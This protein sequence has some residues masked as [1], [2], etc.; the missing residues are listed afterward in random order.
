METHLSGE[1]VE[2]RGTNLVGDKITENKRRLPTLPTYSK[3]IWENKTKDK[4][5]PLKRTWGKTEDKEKSLVH[6]TPAQRKTDKPG[7]K[8]IGATGLYVQRWHQPTDTSRSL[9]RLSPRQTLSLSLALALSLSPQN[10]L[11]PNHPRRPW[12]CASSSSAIPRVCAAASL[13]PTS[14]PS[15]LRSTEAAPCRRCPIR[16][17]M[18]P[19]MKANCRLPPRPST[20][21]QRRLHLYRSSWRLALDEGRRCSTS[22]RPTSSSQQ[23]PSPKWV[24]AVDIALVAMPKT[25]VLRWSPVTRRTGVDR[26]VPSMC[27]LSECVILILHTVK[28]F[29]EHPRKRTRQT[30]LWKLM[31]SGVKQTLCR[32]Y[33]FGLYALGKV[34]NSSSEWA[35]KFVYY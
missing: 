35:V 5:S 12:P 20:C 34:V 10:V 3:E 27:Y 1:S 30:C 4:S 7:G 22:T 19:S 29:P 33:F 8:S 31:V 21:H 25:V 6:N 16:G 15:L 17:S 13:P 24:P 18:R 26:S 11:L 23:V 9:S 32:I 28:V 14:G 2:K